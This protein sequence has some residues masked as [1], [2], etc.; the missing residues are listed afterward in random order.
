MSNNTQGLRKGPSGAD[1]EGHE[2]E[3]LRSDKN[4]AIHLLYLQAEISEND[5][6]VSS[7]REGGPGSAVEI[8]KVADELTSLMADLKE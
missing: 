6:W 5:P 2:I 8:R 1:A 4:Q 7:L 3:G